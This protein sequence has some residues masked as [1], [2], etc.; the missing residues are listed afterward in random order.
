MKIKPIISEIIINENTNL[1]FLFSQFL[2]A[3][4]II[5]NRFIDNIAISVPYLI[6]V[7]YIIMSITCN[8]IIEIKRKRICSNSSVDVFKLFLGIFLSFYSL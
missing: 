8:A 4:H 3:T 6:Q 7:P 2:I 5:D 1:C